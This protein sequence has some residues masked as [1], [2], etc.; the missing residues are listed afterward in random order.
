MN[1][2]V[3]A[4]DVKRG[5]FLDD[6]R[7]VDEG[8]LEPKAEVEEDDGAEV[9]P[10]IEK[11]LGQET[12][13]GAAGG[14]EEGRDEG[15]EASPGGDVGA[16][17][18]EGEKIEDGPEDEDDGGGDSE[19]EGRPPIGG[20]VAVLKQVKGGLV[21]LVPEVRDEEA[22]DRD[23]QKTRRVAQAEDSE[24]EEL[25]ADVLHGEDELVGDFAQPLVVDVGDLEGFGE[26]IFKRRD[27][28]AFVCMHH[29]AREATEEGDD[30]RQQQEQRPV[31]VAA[32][33]CRPFGCVGE[34]GV[35]H[36]NRRNDRRPVDELDEIQ[37]PRRRRRFRAFHDQ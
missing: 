30:R 21:L 13:D 17:V 16:E 36:E 1:V 3:I 25:E 15:E 8:E 23:C 33:E 5:P 35:G 32:E 14:D 28:P 37:H 4:D 19:G 34:N 18:V 27:L 11:G 2:L 10:L 9:D 7:L 24:G 29:D 22:E 6:G 20:W 12:F 26:G 31:L